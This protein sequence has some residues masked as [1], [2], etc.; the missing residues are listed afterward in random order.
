MTDS[1]GWLHKPSL[2]RRDITKL[3]LMISSLPIFIAAWWLAAS[4]LQGQGQ[5]Y[6]PTPPEVWGALVQAWTRDPV[7]GQSLLTNIFSSLSR[8][9]SGFALALLVAVPLGL[10]I[11][12]ISYVDAFTRPI[13]EILRPVPPIAWVVFLLLAFGLFW[14]PVITIFI[15]V[16]FP[17]LSNIIFGVRSVDPILIDAARTQGASG[18]QLFTKVIFPYAV[19]YIMTG[20][21]IGVGIGWMCIVAA[22]LIAVRGGGVGVLITAG[23]SI[24]RYDIMFA[25]MI[26]VG[27]LGIITLA[28]SNY[29]EK[30]VDAWMGM[31]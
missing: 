31:A 13:I 12:T 2:E 28:I 8:F 27:V 3:A 24:G 25:G 16:F 30:K 22:E 6:L 23:Q 18:I 9:L 11:G 21:R 14:G 20:I 5:F 7:T 4:Y 19:P 1:F 10:A 26:T 17:L 15:G 29:V